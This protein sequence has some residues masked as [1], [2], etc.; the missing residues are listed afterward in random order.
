MA[1]LKSYRMSGRSAFWK[2]ILTTAL[3]RCAP[4]SLPKTTLIVVKL[5]K[6]LGPQCFSSSFSRWSTTSLIFLCQKETCFP[7]NSASPH[8]GSRTPSSSSLMYHSGT[9]MQ[10]PK[11][12]CKW[13]RMTCWDMKVQ[14]AS[15]HIAHAVSASITLDGNNKPM[16]TATSANFSSKFFPRDARSNQLPLPDQRKLQKVIHQAI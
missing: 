13:H 6:K 1:N 10:L 2:K 14:L 7:S 15:S 5:L 12:Y 16:C 9:V 8:I 11:N 3:K 4:W